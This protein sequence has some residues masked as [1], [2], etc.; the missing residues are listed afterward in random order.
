MTDEKWQ[1]HLEIKRVMSIKKPSYRPI[2]EIASE[3]NE[4]QKTVTVKKV[5]SLPDFIGL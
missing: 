4:K 1:E 2:W 3:N 5:D